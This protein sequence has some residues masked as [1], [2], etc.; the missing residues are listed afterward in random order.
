LH[1]FAKGGYYV[2]RE[3][4]TLTFI[5]CGSY[6]D[7]P[8][9]ADALHVDIW[10][11]GE[12]ILPDAGSYKYNTDAETIR[13]FSGT[14]SHNTVM[15]DDK[16]QMLKG[17]HFIWFYWTQC[18]KA[19]LTE[20]T[21]SYVFDG[22]VNAF[23]YLDK[24]IEHQRTVVKKK[25]APEW[26]IKDEIV[27]KPTGMKMRQLW[28]VLPANVKKVNITTKGGDNKE[29]T[30]EQGKGWYSSRYGEKEPSVEYVYSTENNKLTTLIKV[31]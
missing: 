9:Q 22:S 1:T 25:G 14:A 11:K 29:L 16:D 27:N 10:Y 19:E 23:I 6:K 4:E 31:Q 15:L 2:I 3:P 13:Y 7:R 21:G 12:N 5:K 8:Q 26:E 28:H 18:T 17:G 20:D 30:V 24:G